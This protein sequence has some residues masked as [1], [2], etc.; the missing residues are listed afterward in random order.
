MIRIH[1]DY[2]LG[3]VLWAERVDWIVIDFEGE[4]G[5]S[6]AERR[7]RTSAL[8]DVAGMLRSFAYAADG[9]RL[10]AQRDVA[11][12]L[13]GSCRSAFL[14]GWRETVDPRLLPS[15]EAG[16]ERLL[17]LFELQKLVY[18]LRYELGNR[19]DWVWIPVAGLER[20]LERDE[21]ADSASS[22]CI[23]PAKAGMNGST[24]GSAPTCVDGGVRFAVWA[25]NA[26]AVSVGRRLELLERGRRPFAR[27]ARRDLGRRRREMPRRGQRYKLAVVG[28]DGITRLKADPYARLAEVPPANA[29]IVY[30][31]A[32][33]VVRRRVARRAAVR[34]TL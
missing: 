9:S 11:G 15:S 10:L 4:P 12:R 16:F 23:W 17:A 34:P 18:E 6:L 21:Q 2:H 13:G 25:P 3:Q 24:S 1:G 32:V 20:M 22:I 19:P 33:P 28:A 26:R 7:R 31:L 27:S 29:S 8:R 5:R 30:Q 14:D